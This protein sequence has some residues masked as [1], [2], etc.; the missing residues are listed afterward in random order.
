MVTIPKSDYDGLVRYTMS[1]FY[2][3]LSYLQRIAYFLSR[4]RYATFSGL[5]ARFQALSVQ[6][7]SGLTV[8]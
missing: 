4:I 1:P 3:T 6:G 7:S 8:Y 5:H 2:E